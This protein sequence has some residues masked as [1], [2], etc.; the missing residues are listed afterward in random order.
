[1]AATSN[2][3]ILLNNRNN[4]KHRSVSCYCSICGIIPVV[5]DRFPSDRHCNI[6]LQG[7]NASVVNITISILTGLCHMPIS[8][9]HRQCE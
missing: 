6:T 3:K 4:E 1:M 8:V 7:E 9:S 5:V 2:R